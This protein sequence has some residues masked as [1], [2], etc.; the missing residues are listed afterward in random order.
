M[1]LRSDNTRWG[2][3][4]RRLIIV[5][6]IVLVAIAGAAIA[7]VTARGTGRPLTAPWAPGK[8]GAVSAAT[9][10]AVDTTP[11]ADL[12]DFIRRSV[13]D[14]G[15]DAQKAVQSIRLVRSNLGAIH[16]ELFIYSLGDSGWC[17]FLWRR[18]ADCPNAQS[19]ATPGAVY[20]LSP[21]GPGY[22]GHDDNVPAA[23]AGIVDDNITSVTLND[24]GAATSLPIINNAFYS[25]LADDPNA[26]FDV[27]L[28]YDY[29][30]GTTKS[31]T[32]HNDGMFTL[33]SSG[34]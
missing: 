20:Y 10:I 24:K 13:S 30:D 29:S 32:L 26:S 7:A 27:E 2:M 12:A 6:A 33:P 23:V 31:S 4:R 11:P 14:A 17:L 34:S 28:R 3:K 9:K 22:V 5:A 1:S 18:Q 15:G 19:T 8:D 16:S 21:G 25:D